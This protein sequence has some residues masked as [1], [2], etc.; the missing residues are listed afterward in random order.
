M[1]TS[2]M[3]IRSGIADKEIKEDETPVELIDLN[4]GWDLKKSNDRE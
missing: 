4:D 2:L 1:L 3:E